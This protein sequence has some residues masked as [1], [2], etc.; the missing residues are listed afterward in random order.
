MFKRCKVVMLP[1]KEKAPIIS[2]NKGTKL[3]F[4]G[5]NIWATK[6]LDDSVNRE[7]LYITSD[8]EIKQGDIFMYNNDYILTLL[9]KD[10]ITSNYISTER[11]SIDLSDWNPKY[12]KKIIATTD[13]EIQGLKYRGTKLESFSKILKG[14]KAQPSQSFIDKYITEYNKGNKIENV[15]VEYIFKKNIRYGNMDLI[16]LNNDGSYYDCT[17]CVIE[18]TRSKEYL[19]SQGCIVD[20]PKVNPKDN[21]ITIKKVKDT[22]TRDEV[23]QLIEKCYFDASPIGKDNDTVAKDTIKWIDTNL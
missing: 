5:E 19:I 16:E 7:H 21:T 6:E 20:E 8:D 2:Y 14:I 15:L 10:T 4:V 18:T 12:C 17:N 11:Y 1:T 22:W 23:I 13:K 3:K 9:C